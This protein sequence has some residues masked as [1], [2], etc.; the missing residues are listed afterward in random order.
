MMQSI[1][2]T[3]LGGQGIIT[4]ANLISEQATDKGLRVTL[5][6]AKGMAQRGGRV[7]SE[8]RLSDDPQAAFGARI[9]AG[10]AD[11]RVPCER[12]SPLQKSPCS[13]VL[14]LNE[15]CSVQGCTFALT[16]FQDAL[17]G[18][19]APPPESKSGRYFPL[20]GN[21]EMRPTIVA[22]QNES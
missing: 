17:P 6:K 20:P 7:T 9:S 10:K 5:F 13:R 14:W 21:A 22:G 18:Q 3:G 2:M 19:P 16:P 4:L 8:I 1:F 15:C 11:I 12:S